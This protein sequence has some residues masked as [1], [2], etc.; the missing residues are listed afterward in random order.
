M[1]YRHMAAAGLA[2]FLLGTAGL[3]E[4]AMATVDMRA[5][6]SDSP[7]WQRQVQ[8]AAENRAALEKELDERSSG[9]T[10]EALSA[11]VQEYR[12]RIHRA[13]REL[14]EEP[15]N[16]ILAVIEEV[17]REEGYTT[18]VRARSVLYGQADGDITAAVK[19]RLERSET[20]GQ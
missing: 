15:Y 4:A 2:A 1:K 13:D 3:A 20:G 16:R 10:G 19:A 9:L 11:L 18:V 17:A 12:E 5:I 7:Q 14:M 6:I 8:Q